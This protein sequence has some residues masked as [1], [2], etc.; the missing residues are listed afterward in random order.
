MAVYVDPLMRHGWVLRGRRVA[1]C[2]MMADTLEELHEMA[3]KI[4]MKR[5]WFQQ[6]GKNIP[7]RALPH[8]DLVESRRRMAV[9][10][11]AVEL[12]SHEKIRETFKH[13]RE[14][15]HGNQ[16]RQEDHGLAGREE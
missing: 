4:G 8:Y 6:P 10:L 5:A 9:S 3:R 14:V 13:L 15:Y 12:D 2:H 11:G 16:D 7:A 1:S